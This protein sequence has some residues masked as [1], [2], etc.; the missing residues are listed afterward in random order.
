MRRAQ[1]ASGSRRGHELRDVHAGA[2]ARRRGG[3]DARGA[4]EFSRP[5]AAARL[6]SVAVGVLGAKRTAALKTGAIG[7]SF[8]ILRV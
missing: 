6:F 2:L 5:S 1:S 4:E 7:S 3:R 8:S